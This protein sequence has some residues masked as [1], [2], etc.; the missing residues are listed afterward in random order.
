M[1]TATSSSES[2]TS[3]GVT[4]K[5]TTSGASTALTCP[6]PRLSSQPQRCTAQV[7]ASSETRTQSTAASQ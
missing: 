7:L 3:T 2:T 5:I 6:A 4:A 1:N